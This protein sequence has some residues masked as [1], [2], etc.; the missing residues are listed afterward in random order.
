MGKI[1]D[2]RAALISR[3]MLEEL[4]RAADR[5]LEDEELGGKYLARNEEGTGYRLGFKEGMGYEITFREIYRPSTRH[6]YDPHVD[7][8]ERYTDGPI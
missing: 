1:H 3:R 2:E 8:P 7:Y 4:A 6:D 5:L